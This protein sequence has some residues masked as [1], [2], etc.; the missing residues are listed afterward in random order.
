V[1]IT[2]N[3]RTG[4]WEEESSN[5][6]RFNDFQAADLAAG[7]ASILPFVA[8]DMANIADMQDMRG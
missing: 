1:S 8:R 6:N 3:T 7:A 4:M 2:A 5:A